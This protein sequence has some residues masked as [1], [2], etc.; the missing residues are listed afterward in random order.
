[1]EVALEPK[2]LLE[3]SRVACAVGGRRSSRSISGTSSSGARTSAGFLRLKGSWRSV[4]QFE[5]EACS[6]HAR[7]QESKKGRILQEKAIVRTALV[8]PNSK[9]TSALFASTPGGTYSSQRRSIRTLLTASL[10]A[11]TCQIQKMLKEA[12]QIPWQNDL[13]W[14]CPSHLS[15]CPYPFRGPQVYTPRSI[16]MVHPAARLQQQFQNTKGGPHM[17]PKVITS[18]P[19]GQPQTG[20]HAIICPRTSSS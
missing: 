19:S 15:Q 10:E 2:G 9:E 4:G 14:R 20:H 8:L 7:L 5:L 16:T 18:P 12:T 1:M 6:T 13:D 17:D 11:T 3:R